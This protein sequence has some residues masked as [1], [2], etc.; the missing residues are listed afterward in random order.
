VVLRKPL[1]LQARP[2]LEAGQLAAKRGAP[3]ARPSGVAIRAARLAWLAYPIG[4]LCG[5]AGVDA[6]LSLLKPLNAT[7]RGDSVAFSAACQAQQARL[8]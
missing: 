4:W 5:E 1:R 7:R 3:P 2:D 6:V 8:E